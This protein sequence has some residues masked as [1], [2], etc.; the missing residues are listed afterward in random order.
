MRHH[1]VLFLHISASFAMAAIVEHQRV[2]LTGQIQE[3]S[4]HSPLEACIQAVIRSQNETSTTVNWV[5]CQTKI[6]LY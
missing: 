4:Q 2:S 3:K 1:E 5:S 6:S